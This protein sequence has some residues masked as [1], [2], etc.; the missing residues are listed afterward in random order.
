MS[1]KTKVSV[2][3]AL[4]WMLLGTGSA[5]AQTWSQLVTAGS[6]PSG[7]NVSNYDGTNNR[8]I[9]FFPRNGTLASDEVWVLTNANGLGGTPTWLQLAPTGT[10]PT[11]NV[12]ATA[13]YNKPGNKLIVYGGCSG[14]C[15]SPL[16]DV[17]VLTHANGLG[18]TPAWSK[19]ASNTDIPRENHR[20]VL[21][22]NTNSMITFGGGLAAFGTD[23]N[24]TNV[25]TP[26]TG[27]SPTWTTLA[28]SGGPP[29]VREGHTAVYDQADNRMI[30]FGG[31]DAISTC[32]PYDISNYNDV[33]VLSN[34]NG[35]GGSPT[36]TEL[37]PQGTAPLGRSEHAA[38]YLPG[39]NAMYVFGGQSWSNAT[40]TYTILGDVW[41]L[42]NANGLGATPSKWTQVGQLGTPPG[43]NSIGGMSFDRASQRIIAFGGD[44]GNGHPH[45]LAFI[46]DLKQH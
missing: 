35:Q 43:A 34:A 33:W 18:G 13:V 30:I 2:A 38:V 5:L 41:R 10:A 22:S 24:D 29:G 39:Q 17:Y 45:N 1:H 6:P 36:W 23:Q 3:T 14:N 21:D 11:I 19:S 26:A 12:F 25:L 44:D 37:E 20:A 46:L 4:T 40:Q 28:P 27:S 15:G 16:P 8:L 32:C 7:E 42:N 9:V 31:D